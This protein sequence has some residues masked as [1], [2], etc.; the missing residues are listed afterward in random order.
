MKPPVPVTAAI[1]EELTTAAC[2]DCDYMEQVHGSGHKA[3]THAMD[4]AMREHHT[5][6]ERTVTQRVI[7]PDGGRAFL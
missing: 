1:V 4:H 2:E 5:V 7:R 6:G 3:S